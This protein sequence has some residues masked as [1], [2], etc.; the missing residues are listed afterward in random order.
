M[1]HISVKIMTALCC[2]FIL[3]PYFI[4]INLLFKCFMMLVMEF[5][6]EKCAY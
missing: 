3:L 4:F 5:L 2:G 6:H 1:H